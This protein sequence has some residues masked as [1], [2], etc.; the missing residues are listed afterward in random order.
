MSYNIVLSNSHKYLYYRVPKTATT[1]IIKYLE[2]HTILDIGGSNCDNKGYNLEY[3]ADWD[4][5]FQF[6]FVRNPWDRILSCF[7]DKTK[8]CIGKPWEL[9]VYKKYY[10]SS[11]E[12]FIFCLNEKNILLDGHTYPQCGMINTE[13]LDFIG[14]FENLDNDFNII[15]SKLNIPIAKLPIENITHHDD[16]RKYYN[17]N[18]KNKIEQLY[19]KDIE[20]FQYEF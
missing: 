7:L 4:S 8:Q 11:F 3:N 13:H 14:K 2:Q 9:E 6:V 19:S 12:D 18:T 20:I 1:S 15:Q 5:L 17:S 10:N 16:Y